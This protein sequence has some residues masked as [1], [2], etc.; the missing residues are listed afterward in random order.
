MI[1][2]AY[3]STPPTIAPRRLAP[4]ATVD[5]DSVTFTGVVAWAP[6]AGQAD[7]LVVIGQVGDPAA[8]GQDDAHASEGTVAV[9]R[10]AAAH[11]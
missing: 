11:A 3:S 6:D 4:K 7:V 5:G 9:L 2:A 1:S 10:G 8:V